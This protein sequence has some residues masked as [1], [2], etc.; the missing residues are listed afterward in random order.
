MI[1]ERKRNWRSSSQNKVKQSK[2]KHKPLTI[3][4]NNRTKLHLKNTISIKDKFVNNFLIMALVNVLNM[5]REAIS[6][7]RSVPIFSLKKES[8]PILKTQLGNCTPA[9]EF[10]STLAVPKTNIIT[11]LPFHL[12]LL[13]GLTLP[14][15]I[16]KSNKLFESFSIWNNIWVFG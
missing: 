2:P 13:Y 7:F 3:T 16:R 11:F 12:S 6:F 1:P 8:R 10:S 4:D 14:G 15:R 9:T 5:V